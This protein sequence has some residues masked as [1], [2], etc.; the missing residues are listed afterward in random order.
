MKKI[1]KF[2]FVV[3]ILI[4]FITK[5]SAL[6]VSEDNI[7]L[8]TGEDKTIDLYAN[9]NEDV[10]SV[11]FTLVYS[12]YD[13]P[14][15]FTV[16][17]AYTDTNPDGI[18]HTINF[19]EPVTGKVKLGSIYI[20][21]KS[22]PNDTSGTINIHSANAVGLNDNQINLKNLNI[23]IKINKI[24]TPPEPNKDEPVD[25]QEEKTYN[26][27]KS[28][29]SE[30]IKLVIKEN[31]FEYK[32]NVKK[33]IDELDLKPVAINDN[34]QVEISNQKVSELTDGL[35]VIKVTDDN[36]HTQEYKIQVN[37]LEDTKDI[38]IDDSN[39]KEK[40]IY[41]GKWIATIVILIIILV[42]GAIFSKK[43]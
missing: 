5:V 13:I 4:I 36:S 23:N 32:V 24:V 33:D 10:T 39:F 21:P 43:K 34:Y 28:V 17:S 26:L 40:N 12:T 42:L 11:T 37:V 30:I 19:S 31:V 41:K 2:I 27:L 8:N 15:Y 29:D 3:F 18:K 6:S 22:D 7:V 35:I 9:V 1:K 16:N 38:Q 14:A 25:N 20:K